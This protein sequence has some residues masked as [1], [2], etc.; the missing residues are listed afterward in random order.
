MQRIACYS[1]VVL[2]SLAGLAGCSSGWSFGKWRDALTFKKPSPQPTLSISQMEMR[3]QQLERIHEYD[4]AT[5]VYNQILKQDHDNQFAQYRLAAIQQVKHSR[6]QEHAYGAPDRGSSPVSTR[7]ETRPPRAESLPVINP[8]PPGSA[9]PIASLGGAVP[10]SGAA[11][12]S[13]T[14]FP[15]HTS[16]NLPP[17][18]QPSASGTAPQVAQSDRKRVPL[19]QLMTRTTDGGF[20]QPEPRNKGQ[21]TGSVNLPAI[22]DAQ[23]IRESRNLNSQSGVSQV[24]MTTTLPQIAQPDRPAPASKKLTLIEVQKRLSTHPA[25]PSAIEMLVQGIRTEDRIGRWEISSTLGVLIQN[26]DS[27][28]LIVDSLSRALN[29]QEP[30]MRRNTA[31][32][33]ASL[34]RNGRD[35]LPAAEQRLNDPEESVR[36]AAA[37]AIGEI[38]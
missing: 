10:A 36:Q 6:P 14:N 9:R 37:Y 26:P 4:A 27:K 3:A 21:Q 25:D 16:L 5:D 23:M 33:I 24:S 28:S 11:A 31:L 32:V 22:Y 12:R 18:A 1:T 20:T 38:R 13:R 19:D 30:E 17:W 8:G 15:G 2:I 7:T 34:G 35:L 29:D